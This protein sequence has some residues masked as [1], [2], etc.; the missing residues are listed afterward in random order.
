MVGGFPRTDRVPGAEKDFFISPPM[1][2][3]TARISGTHAELIPDL[4]H[5]IDRILC[6]LEHTLVAKCLR[7]PTSERR[8][9]LVASNMIHS[10]IEGRH[11]TAFRE[12]AVVLLPCKAQGIM[13]G[14]IL[15]D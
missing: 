13:L 12:T 3:A 2:E 1:V 14:G 8:L 4:T 6:W 15:C 9:Y 10:W 7:D 11:G 5:A